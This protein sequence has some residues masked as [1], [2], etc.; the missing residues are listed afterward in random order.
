MLDSILDSMLDFLGGR[1]YQALRLVKFR[2]NTTDS[3]VEVAQTRAPFY[4]LQ[5]FNRFVRFFDGQKGSENAK[6][7]ANTT[8]TLKL[9][10]L[11]IGR[12]F[13]ISSFLKKQP[14]L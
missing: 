13:S 10:F 7:L 1:N 8:E 9:P 14:K 2:V 6:M 12:K 11:K 3:S 4:F 5:R